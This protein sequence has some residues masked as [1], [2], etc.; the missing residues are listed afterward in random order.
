MAGDPINVNLKAM[1]V[2]GLRLIGTTLRSRTSKAKAQILDRMVRE[3]WPKV[4]SGEIHPT[5]IKVLPIQQAE[6]AQAL[7]SENKIVGKIVLTV[8]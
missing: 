5:I 3:I 6:E 7:M 8:R 4:K 1:Y 2:K